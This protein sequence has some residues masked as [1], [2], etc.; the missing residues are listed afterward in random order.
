M[1]EMLLNVLTI[2]KA[3]SITA[4]LCA[5]KNRRRKTPRAVLLEDGRK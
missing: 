3:L 1:R 4:F 2:E 5:R